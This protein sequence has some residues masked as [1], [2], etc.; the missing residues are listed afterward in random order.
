MNK[1]FDWKNIKKSDWLVLALIGAILLVIVLPE[2][3][4]ER[5]NGQDIVNTNAAATSNRAENITK[6][7]TAEYTSYLEEK[8]E[9]VLSEIEG[10]GNVRVMLTLSDKGEAIVEKD[11]KDFS[12]S[13]KETGINGKTR[14][15]VGFRNDGSTVTAGKFT[16]FRLYAKDDVNKTNLLV[17]PDFKM[18][19]YGWYD[20][21]GSYMN[22]SQL[23]E[24]EG[25]TTK[26]YV[27]LSNSINNYEYYETFQNTGYTVTQGDANR[28]SNVNIL[29]FIRVNKIASGDGKYYVAADYDENGSITA[30]D[31]I[32][33]KKQ[34]LG[35]VINAGTQVNVSASD[36]LS[37]IV[38][39]TDIS[40]TSGYSADY[41]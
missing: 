2:S 26:G 8:L 34:L 20:E 6:T 5:K 38:S 37:A 41:K 35:V 29:D 21:A 27:T 31:L 23:K 25:V 19:L 1:Q 16:N 33:L 9:E 12:N 24:G 39:E 17:N 32:Y 3:D 14:V 10:V 15:I 36:V 40:A 30:S 7:D 28:D 11:T 18:G 22:Y 4:R 13:V